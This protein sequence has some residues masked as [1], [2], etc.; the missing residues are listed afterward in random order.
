[1]RGSAAMWVSR[2]DFPV[3]RLTNGHTPENET[4]LRGTSWESERDLRLDSGRDGFVRNVLSATYNHASPKNPWTTT[5]VAYKVSIFLGMRKRQNG[6]G[7][8]TERRPRRDS[9]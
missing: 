9:R 5:C 3:N 2:R 6:H 4:P 1:M 7:Q 8:K